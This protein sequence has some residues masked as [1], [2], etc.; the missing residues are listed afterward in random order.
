MRNRHK[1]SFI[2]SCILADVLAIIV[3][4]FIFLRYAQLSNVA[5]DYFFLNNLTS[6]RLFCWILPALYFRLY[7]LDTE[8]NLD[9]FYRYTWRVFLLQAFLWQS[10]IYLIHAS[11]NYNFVFESNVYSS[12]FL[13]VYCLFSRITITYILINMKN[14][15]QNPFKVA[16]WGFNKTSIGLASQIEKNAHFLNFLGIINSESELKYKSKKEFG[17]VLQ[18]AIENASKTGIQE[19]YIVVQPKYITDLN[20]FFELADKLC[21]RL[22]FVPDFSMLSKEKFSSSSYHNFQV[23]KPREEPLQ[24][25]SNLLIKR[26][27]DVIFS[28]LVVILIL[29]WL[30]PILA[31]LIKK[32]SKGPILFKQLR[33]G[34]K[35]QPFWCY[36]FRS[37][38]VN[39][40][41]DSKQAQKEDD[42]VTPIG[43]FIRRT[44]LDELPQ[45]FNVLL[46][47]MSVVG[48]RP[49]M[50]KHT[51]DYNDL[52]HNFMVR[53]FVKPGIT[54]WAQ[55]SGHRGETKE[56]I[57][58]KRRVNADINYVLNWSLIKD[59]KICF[60]TVIITLKGDVNA[61]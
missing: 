33:T 31:F 57:D 26:V 48:P 30:F 11:K 24:K 28:L 13:M 1:Y 52:I 2:F 17:A 15:I 47:D 59:I 27:F 56:V 42:R 58:M 18:H 60:L 4:S 34:K 10:Y 44:S 7:P 9:A 41:S 20:H 6:A 38:R 46:G 39:T 54:G 14:W 23:L 61:F 32:Q 35:N 25:S 43:K 19:M 21:M 53:H 16:I 12:S 55:V 29:S 5:W 40:V 49:H 51:D 36:K 22:K 45:F 50:L 3:A 8:F 37:M